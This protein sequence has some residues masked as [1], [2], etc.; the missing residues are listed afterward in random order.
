MGWWVGPFNCW[1]LSPLLKSVGTIKMPTAFHERFKSV[2]GRAEDRL[3]VSALMRSVAGEFARAYYG[4]KERLNAFWGDNFHA[5]LVEGGHYL[6]QCLCYVELN[7]IRCRPRHPLSKLSACEA[8]G[9]WG[10]QKNQP[11]SLSRC[12]VSQQRVVGMH[13]PRWELLGG[14]TGRVEWRRGKFRS[15]ASNVSTLSSIVANGHQTVL[16]FPPPPLFIP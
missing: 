15:M 2:C 6:W 11:P 9:R 7:M 13:V 14:W 8:I 5:T 16:S 1:S 3:E 10:S 12:L 4:R